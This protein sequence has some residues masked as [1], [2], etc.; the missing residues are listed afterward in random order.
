MIAHTQAPV[1]KSWSNQTV[2]DTSKDCLVCGKYRQGNQVM[3]F[4][5]GDVAFWASKVHVLSLS[6][7]YNTKRYKGILPVGIL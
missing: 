5:W 1:P 7:S 3:R 6:T 4:V 2:R